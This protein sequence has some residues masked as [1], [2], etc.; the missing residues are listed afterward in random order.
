MNNTETKFKLGPNQTKW[1]EALKSG[2]YKQGKRFLH[3]ITK[4]NNESSFCC[5]GVA[6]DL[7]KEE[8]NINFQLRLNGHDLGGFY[9]DGGAL[10][11]QKIA[12]HLGLNNI[13]GGSSLKDGNLLTKINDNSNDF[14]AVIK[15]LEETP[16]LYF[17]ESK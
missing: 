12:D 4:S 9:N 11:P 2:E 13:L 6:C 7:F 10:P 1:L 17:K 3:R 14:N 8:L 16:E 5:L 15:V